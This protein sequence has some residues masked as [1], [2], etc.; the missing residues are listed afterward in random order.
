MDFLAQVQVHV[1]IDPQPSVANGKHFPVSEVANELDRDRVRP[2]DRQVQNQQIG[3]RS[4]GFLPRVRLNEPERLKE[5][6]E[7]SEDVITRNVREQRC[8][9][10]HPPSSA[11][12]AGG[13]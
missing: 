4:D 13:L 10:L 1:A 9:L 6:R 5:L 2:H 11:L 3:F 7:L 8:A 12:A